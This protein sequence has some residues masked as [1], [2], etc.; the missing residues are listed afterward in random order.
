[1]KNWYD[2]S[3]WIKRLVAWYP[4]EIQTNQPVNTW[5]CNPPRTLETLQT[6]IDQ[7]WPSMNS[8]LVQNLW[9]NNW[10]KNN[11]S[12]ISW[13]LVWLVAGN[14]I[15][16]W[17]SCCRPSTQPFRWGQGH[18]PDARKSEDPDATSWDTSLRARIW[19]RGMTCSQ[20]WGYVI[21]TGSMPTTWLLYVF[22]LWECQQVVV[23][24]VT[25]W[26]FPPLK[27]MRQHWVCPLVKVETCSQ[28]TRTVPVPGS[29]GRWASD[30]IRRHPQVDL[31]YTRG[32]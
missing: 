29:P 24:C 23:T 27:I 1:M 6:N 28:G 25:T 32:T 26:W 17:S 10:K 13:L 7:I 8:Q 9:T 18:L 11:I 5:A 3:K 21:V 12:R 14:Y 15:E 2:R 4:R 31:G 20:L 30:M 19:G 22:Q 16:V